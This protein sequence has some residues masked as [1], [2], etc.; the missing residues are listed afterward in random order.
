[1]SGNRV[2]RRMDS[3]RI[4]VIVAAF[5][6][7]AAACSGDDGDSSPEPGPT[8]TSSGPG[9]VNTWTKAPGSEGELSVSLSQGEASETIQAVV[10]VVEGQ[11]LDA[12][13]IAG[14]VDRLPEWLVDE[15][16]KFDFRL[17][18]ESLPRPR[19]GDTLDVAFP[20]LDD[21]LPPEV[22]SG[23]LEVLRMQ[24]EGD[25]GLAPFMSLT[26]N[27]PMVPIGTV[28]QLGA[29]D[30]PVTISPDLPGRWQ[31]IGTRTLRFEHDP[32]VFD[33]LPMATSF[34]VV[35]PAGTKAVSGSALA[36]T[37]TWTFET[38]AAS[39]QWLSPQ[40]DSVELEPVFF[41]AFDQRVDPDAVLEVTTLTAGGDERGLRLATEEEIEADA[42]AHPQAESALRGTWLA[43]RAVEPFAPDQQLH[44]EIGPN[45]PSIEGPNT[46]G[47][48][49]RF[50]ARTFAPL[51]V[52]RHSCQ[53]NDRCEPG[54]GLSVSF[55]N[56]LDPESLDLSKLTIDPAIPGASITV[57][58]NDIYIQGETAGDT[59]YHV[60]IPG[61][62]TDVF[63]QTF[64]QDTTLD[65]EVGPATPLIQE[66][67]RQFLTLDPLAEG[68]TFPVVVR[69]HDKLRVR[70][71][72][73]GPDD[74]QE[75]QNHLER[76]Y[77]S[78]G[79][80]RPPNFP[81]LSDEVIST[82]AADDIRSEVRID[83]GSVLNGGHGHVVVRIDGTGRYADLGPRDDDFWQNAPQ[84]VWVQD[85]SI[86]LDMIYDSTTGV[87]WTTDL[88]TG[89]PLAGVE[90]EATDQTTTQSVAATTDTNGL[91]E[92]QLGSLPIRA[93]VAR[94]GDD[95]AINTTWIQRGESSDQ[96]IWYVVDDR[97]MYRPG[98]T[99]RI[100]GWVRELD[101][102]DGDLEYLGSGE[103]ITYVARDSFGNELDRGGLSPDA[104]GGF[105]LELDLPLG[106]NLGH[107]WVEFQRIANRNGGFYNHSFE[108]QE[109]R[110]PEFEVTT[111]AES[112]GPYY[113]DEPAT[114]AV[115]AEYFSGG[116]LPDAPVEW[117]VTTQSASYSPPNWAEFTFGVWTPWWIFN[118][119]GGFR[120]GE[121][122]LDRGFF[123]GPEEFGFGP[124]TES[125][126]EEFSGVTDFSGNH[127]LRMDFAGDGDGLPTSVTAEAS[128]TDV[129]RQVWADRTDVLVHPA[130]LYVGLR[131]TRT[132]VRAGD[133]LDVEAIVT[134]VDGDAVV[135]RGFTML[136]ERL[137]NQYVDG[138]WT[139]VAVETETCDSTSADRAV[140]CTFAM[141]NGGRYRISAE[142]V[143]DAGR[144]SRSEMTRWVTG[145]DAVASRALDLQAVTLVPDRPTYAVGDTAEILVESPFGPATGLL[146]YGVGGIDATEVFAIDSGSAVV[147]IPIDEASVPGIR[148]QIEL[149]GTAL[150]AADDGTTL[151]EVP[152][153]PAYA[154][155]SLD[156]RVPPATRTLDVTA[157]PGDDTLA[158]GSS[159]S[160][161]VVVKDASGA[162]VEG[163]QMLVVVV[164]EAILAL[165]G[166]ELLD[167]LDVFYRSHPGYI[168][169]ER[170]RDSILLEDPQELI[171]LI[172]AKAGEATAT[173]AAAALGGDDG[174]DSASPESFNDSPADAD[175]AA[176][177]MSVQSGSPVEV[178][179][180]F[181]ALAVFA[182]TVVTSDDGTAEVAFDLPDNLTR[183]R[184]MVVAVAGSDQFGSGES[185]ITAQLPLQVRPSVPRFLN[186][187]DDL[188]LPIVVQNLTDVAAEV[189]VVI[190]TSNLEVV[191][192]AGRRVT[193]PANNRIEVRFPIRTGSAGTAR[194]RAV[195]VGAS[196]ADA[197]IVSLPVY[198]PATTEAFATYGVIDQGAVIQPLLAPEG[199]YPQFGGLEIDTSSTALQALTDAVIYLNNYEYRSADGY[200]SRILAIAALRDVLDAFDS[201]GLPDK[202]ALESSVRSDITALSALQ[203]YDGGF[204]SWRR[205][206]RSSPFRS[207]QAMHALV[208]AKANGFTV[209]PEVMQMGHGYLSDIESHI[210][211]DWGQAT[212]DM[213]VAYS[214]HVRRLDGD[215]DSSRARTLWNRSGSDLGLDALAWIWP[216]VADPGIERDI[217]RT[218]NNR[219]TETPQAATFVTSYGEDD[220]LVLNSDRRTDGVVLDALLTMDPESD[221]IPKVVTGLIGNQ[222]KGRWNNVQE[223]AFILLALN[224]YFDTFESVDPDFV[225]RVW[226][227][228]LYAAQHEFVGRSTDRARALVPMSELLTR[229]GDDLIVSKDGEGRLYYR[230]GLRYAPDDLDLDPL[231]RGFVVQ[232]TYEGVDDPGDVWLGSDG[233]WHVNAGAAVRVRVT[234]VNDSRRT[235][236]ALIDPLPAGLEPLNP[237][238]AVSG[239]IAIDEFGSSGDTIPRWNWTWYD[240]QNLRDDRAEAF[241]SY[242]RAGT[243][244]YSYVARATT[245]G[246]FIVP[247]SRAEEIYS[248]EVFGRSGSDV[249]VI[250]EDFRP[251]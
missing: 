101:L 154:S 195:V 163:A 162:P 82:D 153:R 93:L 44:I 135:N 72:S 116:P 81:L 133:P 10:A 215:I 159:T 217:A 236:M 139:D 98:E 214:L 85:T 179:Q 235:N 126:V 205:D 40:H 234:M 35:V 165:S 63:E 143:D 97:G 32:E 196:D 62:L 33:R 157:T 99:V 74:W 96:T 105:D 128:V 213:L 141:A 77:N 64:G 226:L 169:T 117:R 108:I 22:D 58:W 250:E 84:E 137:V 131:A 243:H 148:V 227:G 244:E 80:V 241:S 6:V 185:T 190:E 231:D 194:F 230:L 118:D 223:N 124:Q 127:Y 1:M 106:A 13:A 65:F 150:R 48:I 70:T 4:V 233:V 145:G 207:V 175:F 155:G 164:D 15:A 166:Y 86:G 247:P 208:E 9:S 161:S 21:P 204:G 29:L 202:A 73:V 177:R 68:Q 52:E 151:P 56:A 69:N 121:A 41:A 199:V 103:S 60:T 78:D 168:G 79:P 25:V 43:F 189:D 47:D 39:V 193:V 17:P 92:V 206:Q 197:A 88:R 167:P 115:S 171:D 186:F 218:F 144:S 212:K 49:G 50:D 249:V 147:Q 146:T 104:S 240:H 28:E 76:R 54:R 18:V 220:Y 109:F 224:N 107:G 36:E 71:Y 24:P 246:T 188:E 170:G 225:A 229:G 173:T 251:N 129:N 46:T 12:Q 87:A 2:G 210:P 134:N 119:F 30:V 174:P 91:A 191:G 237:A 61:T 222:V 181:D 221:L 203:N 102:S 23:P 245:L 183:Y 228:D 142:V 90:V 209:R 152:P 201:D 89:E 242:L 59:T 125:S 67:E 94:L 45:I 11:P 130:S 16:D 7:L 31:W 37:V 42:I 200:A 111:R 66:V 149:V 219:V 110:R 123:D 83:L 184:V 198:T 138:E 176:G 172:Q 53:G 100:K 51:R 187:G 122:S 38:P 238:L 248:P 178:R 120:G 216:V 20:A 160:V 19:T 182:P 27:H 5:A 95:S 112:P 158:P 156:L 136:A 55:N 140:S 114:V 180:N 132:F 232:R 239:D 26:F 75:F 14:V 8:S 57:Q 34:E 192:S 113:V 3:I 211:Q